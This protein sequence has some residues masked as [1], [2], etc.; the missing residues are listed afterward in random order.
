[1]EFLQ[2]EREGCEKWFS[3]KLGQRFC[4]KTCKNVAQTAARKKPLEEKECVNPKCKAKFSTRRNAKK[5]CSM[6]CKREHEHEKYMLLLNTESKPC[7]RKGCPQKF[8]GNKK[9]KY[10]SRMCAKIAKKERD[11]ERRTKS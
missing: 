10:C 5:Y 3:G 6:K 7:E 9:Q 11:N 8:V 1:M 4:S 2:C